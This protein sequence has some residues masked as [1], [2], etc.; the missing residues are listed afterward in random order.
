MLNPDL[1][2][3]APVYGPV[4]TDGY[5]YVQGRVP[6]RNTWTYLWVKCSPIPTVHH[7]VVQASELGDELVYQG[8][9]LPEMP[10]VNPNRFGQAIENG[11]TTRIYRKEAAC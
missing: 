3:E 10:G 6:G 4:C 11:V 9:Y 7:V 8:D 1:C 5:G 2:T